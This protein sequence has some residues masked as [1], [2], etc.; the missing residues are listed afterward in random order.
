MD[1][2]K[3]NIVYKPI[4]RFLFIIFHFLL[5][6][7]C[8]QNRWYYYSKW[9]IDNG[10]ER[11]LTKYPLNSKSVVIDVGGY[12]GYFSNKI[13]ELYNP[14][15]II[16]EPVKKFY[17][18]LKNKY[19][20]NKNVKIYN[21]GLSDKNSQQKIFLS[22]DGTSLIKKSSRSEKIK[23]VDVTEHITK[24]KN[25]DLMSLNIEGEEYKL[26]NRLIETRILKNIRFLQVQFHDFVPGAKYKRT[27]IL[28]SI[29]KTHNIRYSYPF[30]WESFEKK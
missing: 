18:I 29:L 24:I 10:D 30:V 2:L 4:K 21:Y 14:H 1:K 22:K 3:Q 8:L 6:N 27:N 9:V 12:T 15:L 7:V 28:K 11:L 16:F 17:E 13:V 19:A 20:N 5:K 23:L 25:I 26:L